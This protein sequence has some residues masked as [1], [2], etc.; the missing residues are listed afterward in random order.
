MYTNLI[1]NNE[2]V[3]IK[4]FTN[5][6][7]INIHD[8]KTIRV[9]D[10][11]YFR[12]IKNLILIIYIISLIL[13]ISFLNESISEFEC[14]LSII[15][16]FYLLFYFSNLDYIKVIITDKHKKYVLLINR[17]KTIEIQELIIKIEMLEF[18]KIILE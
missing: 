4:S 17:N 3:M 5:S 16:L 14:L 13:I 2:F 18:H 1:I 11:F 15:I 6:K 7:K 9:N 12:L 8:I 10:I